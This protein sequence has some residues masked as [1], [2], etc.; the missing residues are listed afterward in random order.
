MTSGK[1]KQ[2]KNRTMKIGI[3]KISSSSHFHLKTQSMSQE[4]KGPTWMISDYKAGEDEHSTTL[5]SQSLKYSWQPIS[6]GE[7]AATGV[8]V[9]YPS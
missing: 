1:Y 8:T 4:S 6:A 9:I 3:Y 5:G 2:V 7:R